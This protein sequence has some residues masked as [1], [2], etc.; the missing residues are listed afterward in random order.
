MTA[1]IRSLAYWLGALPEIAAASGQ[2]LNAGA[3]GIL[4]LKGCTPPHAK[5]NR[6]ELASPRLPG[7]LEYEPSTRGMIKWSP[8]APSTRL[9]AL[10]S[11]V[12]VSF[13]GNPSSLLHDALFSVS[14][15]GRPSAE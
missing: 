2:I 9:V 11:I 6:P 7:D 3:I 1:K 10:P 4:R 14:R 5:S 15:A 8:S 12:M 13:R